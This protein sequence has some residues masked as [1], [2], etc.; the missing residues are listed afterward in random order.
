MKLKALA[1]EYEEVTHGQKCDVLF[2]SVLKTA[3]AAIAFTPAKSAPSGVD[4]NDQH[5]V[6]N[7]K[8][9]AVANA[10]LDFNTP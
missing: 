4:I 7:E 1:V 2:D 9:N 6:M 8:P 10:S 3:D 5:N